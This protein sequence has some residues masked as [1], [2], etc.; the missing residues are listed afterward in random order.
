MVF[1]ES[2]Q[3]IQAGEEKTHIGAEKGRDGV[4]IP[5]RVYPPGTC[6]NLGIDSLWESSSLLCIDVMTV[7]WEH[8]YDSQSPETHRAKTG[9]K[10][11]DP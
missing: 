2:L 7:Q 4:R 8:H 5:T 6:P 9:A 10:Q 11:E 3:L 1:P